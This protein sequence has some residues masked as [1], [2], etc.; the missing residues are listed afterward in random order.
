MYTHA[1]FVSTTDIS[2]KIATDLI[3]DNIT[4]LAWGEGNLQDRAKLFTTHFVR[5]HEMLPYPLLVICR[6]YEEMPCLRK[7]NMIVGNIIFG[8]V[9]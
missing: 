3:M 9:H 7:H 8:Q 4:N 5:L 1:F 6:K 2:Y